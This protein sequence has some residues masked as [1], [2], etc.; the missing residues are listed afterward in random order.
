MLVS[1]PSLFSL[2]PHFSSVTPSHPSFFLSLSPSQP[3][4]SPLQSKKYLENTR[5]NPVAITQK[6]RKNPTAITQKPNQ[7]IN[8]KKKKKTPKTSLKIPIKYQEKKKHKRKK[9]LPKPKKSI[10]KLPLYT[11]PKIAPKPNNKP[12]KNPQNL[13]AN[14]LLRSC[15]VVGIGVGVGWVQWWNG[16]ALSCLDQSLNRIGSSLNSEIEQ[17]MRLLSAVVGGDKLEKLRPWR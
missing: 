10:L 4:L 13:I 1:F 5:K 17:R 6:L 8:K 15:A 16:E 9:Q 14:P 7:K 3:T 2:L 11:P 12:L